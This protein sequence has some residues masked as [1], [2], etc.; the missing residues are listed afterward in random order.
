MIIDSEKLHKMKVGL[1]DTM[2]T[3]MVLFFGV[4]GFYLYLV[5]DEKRRREA[6]QDPFPLR[7]GNLPQANNGP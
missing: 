2:I 6:R 7:L 5:Y 3:L 1:L 4:L